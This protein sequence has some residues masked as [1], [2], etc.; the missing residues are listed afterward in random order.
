MN[1]KL[2]AH[3]PKFFKQKFGRAHIFVSGRVQGI[4]FRS[5]TAEKAKELG[6]TGWVRNL[7]NNRVEAVFEGEEDKI[8]EIIEWV[9]KGPTFARVNGVEILWEDYRG[10]FKNFEIKYN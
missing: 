9:K 1:K 5:N 2:R 6:I 7:D 3:P 10:E 8:K 4:F